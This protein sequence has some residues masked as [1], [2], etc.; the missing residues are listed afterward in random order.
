MRKDKWEGQKG[1][2]VFQLDLLYNWDHQN[3]QQE[4]M[5]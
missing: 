4:L 1:F 2:V 5:G 3:A